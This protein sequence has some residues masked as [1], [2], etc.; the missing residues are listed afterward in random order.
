MTVFLGNYVV[1][2]DNGTAYA[3]QRDDILDAIKT[4]GTD[5]VAGVTVGNEFMLNYL[6]E[7]GASDPNSAV[8]NTGAAILIANIDDTRSALAELSLPKTIPVGN[9]DAGSY[10]NTLVLEAVDY[11]LA[12]VHP[13]FANVSIDIAADWTASFF[14]EVDVV[15]AN[16]LDNQPT[17]YIAETGWPTKS[18][19][20]SNA[21]NGASPASVPNLQIFLDTFVCQAN[22]NGTGYFFFEYFD[23]TWKDALFGGV[24]GWWGL[25]NSN[26]TLKDVTIP[27]CPSS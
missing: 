16:A 23:E 1:P 6:T 21:D 5:H 22:R 8:G 25:F 13:W 14:N 15:P 20:L 24:E 2:G 12:N 7:R 17:M 3:R 9:S 27:D 11:G 10:F 19:D 26:R 18:S 4:Y